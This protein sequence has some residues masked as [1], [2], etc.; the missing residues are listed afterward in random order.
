MAV[1]VVDNAVARITNCYRCA[2]VAASIRCMS[3]LRRG[4]RM[5]MLARCCDESPSP[6]TSSRTPSNKPSR[7]RVGHDHSHLSAAHHQMDIELGHPRQGGTPMDLRQGLGVH[8]SRNVGRLLFGGGVGGCPR[9]LDIQPSRP[10]RH[11]CLGRSC[12]APGTSR[13]EDSCDSYSM[14]VPLPLRCDAAGI[15]AAPRDTHRLSERSWRHPDA[16]RQGA[17]SAS[18]S[19]GCPNS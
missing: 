7:H 16:S 14:G 4:W 13:Q 6:A 19:D 1:C 12:A 3:R 5:N 11:R 2:P 18:P 9:L 10:G 8:S 15:S 17:Q